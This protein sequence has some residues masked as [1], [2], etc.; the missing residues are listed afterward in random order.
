MAY[1]LS[2][3][4]RDSD[5]KDD[6]DEDETEVAATRATLCLLLI[7]LIVLLRHFGRTRLVILLKHLAADV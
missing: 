7:V 4:I 5:G 6:C 1:D 2:S 3:K